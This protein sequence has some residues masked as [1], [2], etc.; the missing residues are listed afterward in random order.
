MDS[1]ETISKLGQLAPHA[2]YVIVIG[3][4]LPPLNRDIDNAYFHNL[5][6]DTKVFTQGYDYAD[7]V[8]IEKYLRQTFIDEKPMFKLT[9]VEGPFF[10][11]PAEYFIA[12]S[13]IGSSRILFGGS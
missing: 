4:S 1:R 12:K 11:V 7:S 6:P 8:R 3:Y 10:Y 9:P 2:S 13:N 5:K